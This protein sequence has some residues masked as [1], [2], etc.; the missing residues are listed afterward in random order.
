M[1]CK[2]FDSLLQAVSVL[3]SNGI[4]FGD[5]SHHNIKVQLST[6]DIRLIDF[7]AAVRRGSDQPSHLFTPAFAKSSRFLR[8]TNDVEDDAYGVA[9]LMMYM[10]FPLPAL[11]SLRDDLFDTVLPT[12]LA[13]LGWSETPV[14]DVIRGLSEN[15]LSFA[16]A[17]GL[18]QKPSTLTSPRFIETTIPGDNNIMIRQFAEFLIASMHPERQSSLLFA[19]PFMYQ[20]NPL[21]LGFGACGVL[22][23]LHRCGF[24]IP[25]SAYDWLEHRLDHTSADDLPPGLLTGFA[26][27]AWTLAELGLD[28]RAVHLMRLANQ[29]F[30]VTYHHSYFYGMAGIGMANLHFYARTGCRDYLKAA[31]DFATCIMQRA[32]HTD[33]GTYW[34][35]DNFV[36]L[37]FGYGQSGVALFLLRLY[38]ATSDIAYRSLG[39]RSLAFDLAH[40]IELESG[41]LSFPNR[42]G[43]TTVLPYLEEGS[44]GIA[45]VAIRYGQW[46]V[47]KTLI[48]DSHRKYSSFPGLLYGLASFIDVHT[49]AF[50]FSGDPTFLKMAQR[51]ISGLKD[52]YLIKQNRG[53]AVP[54][55]G[56]FR[57]SCDYATGVAGVLRTLYRLQHSEAADFFLDELYAHG[58]R[59]SNTR[60][61]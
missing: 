50:I 54:G 11:S 1:Y 19:D 38:E 22:Y 16:A 28:D 25:R 32:Q 7:E 33:R 20:T 17:R 42:P 40:G 44:S 2:I 46:D 45:K 30:N 18:L 57:T 41:I 61:T 10:L 34:E 43:D 37:G 56:L 4:L 53:A 36:H 51:P 15:R 5:L 12:V 3:H 49:D 21:S 48:A 14:A 29:C 39:E 47:A 13:D 55:D 59:G 60:M 27:V 35:A 26:G 31:I 58:H 52:M 9:A 24:E 8:S 23:A 6:Y